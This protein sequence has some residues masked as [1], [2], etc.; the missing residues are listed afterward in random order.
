VKG[1][2]A[3]ADSVAWAHVGS[4]NGMPAYAKAGKVICFFRSAQK[5]KSYPRVTQAGYARGD[6]KHNSRSDV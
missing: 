1:R 5:R 4:G 6:E 2:Y 3:A